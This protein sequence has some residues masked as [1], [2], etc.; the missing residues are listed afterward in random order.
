M[1]R[2]PAA[3]A[4]KFPAQNYGTDR[5]THTNRQT[6]Q[7]RMPGEA[8][9][10][11]LRRVL[12]AFESKIIHIRKMFEPNRRSKLGLSL[13]LATEEHRSGPPFAARS[14]MIYEISSS[15]AID[16]STPGTGRHF[17]IQTVGFYINDKLNCSL[18]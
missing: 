7:G 9:G 18:T 6:Q 13:S 12:T 3:D 17:Y 16:G 15:G 10:G 14:T 11:R 2:L 8:G 1:V 4:S 5:H